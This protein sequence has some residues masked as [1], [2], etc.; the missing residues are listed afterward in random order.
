[1]N[2]PADTIAYPRKVLVR[3]TMRTLSRTLF[4]LLAQVEVIGGDRL[5]QKGPI[6]LA[7]NHVAELETLMMMAYTPG[8]VEFIGTGDIPFDPNYAFL[9]NAYGDLP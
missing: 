6:I 5:P 2:A 3:R 1:M 7:G 4:K 8:L 9:A